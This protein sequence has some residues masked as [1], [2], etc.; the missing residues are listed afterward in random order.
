MKFLVLL[1][2]TGV[3]A[4]NL[5]SPL[6]A[7]RQL[8]EVPCSD[9]GLKDCGEGC[10]Y[11]SYTCCPDGAGGCPA[12]A[13]CNLGTNGEY[14]CCPR[15]SICGGPGGATTIR[16]TQT[17]T[18]TLTVPGE[19]TTIVDESTS[20]IVEESTT[21]IEETFT[22]TSTLSE[23]FTVTYESTTT[24]ETTLS[25]TTAA[26]PT[27]IETESEAP[28][29]TSSIVIVNAGAAN[30]PNIVGGLLAGVAALLI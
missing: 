3:V 13:Y 4:S 15:G 12:S 10:I 24:Y 25:Q 6:L 19:T 22:S 23:T 9:Q 21:V 29:S 8:V 26:P 17:L 18:N 11:L 7:P 30:G 1:A 14:N 16:Q 28:A 2:A 27:R 20:T 5:V